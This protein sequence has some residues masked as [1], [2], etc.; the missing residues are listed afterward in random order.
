MWILIKYYLLKI[1]CFGWMF[2]FF[3]LLLLSFFLAKS[4]N[5]LIRPADGAVGQQSA[6]LLHP[7]FCDGELSQRLDWP[8]PVVTWFVLILN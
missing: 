1:V 6:S 8:S 7:V 4:E 3:K 2:C 5:V